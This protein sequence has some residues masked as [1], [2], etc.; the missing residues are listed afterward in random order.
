VLGFFLVVL[1]SL[2]VLLIAAP[3]AYDQAMRLPAGDRGLEIAVVA[4]LSGLIAVLMVGVLRRWRW[5]FWLVLVAFLFG[6]LR[7]PVAA[8]Q[9]AGVLHADTP[10]WY[11][12]YQAAIG[13]AQ[14][15]IGVAMVAA[16]RRAG[17]W[18]AGPPT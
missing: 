7:L 14:F 10:P 15:A 11:V 17:V 2:P 5:V 12:A 4:G 3:E 8:L 6:I 13:L 1:A 16:Y 9:L 18:G